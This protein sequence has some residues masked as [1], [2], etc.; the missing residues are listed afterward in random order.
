MATMRPEEVDEPDQTQGGSVKQRSFFSLS[1]CAWGWE[2]VTFRWRAFDF[3]FQFS[4]PLLDL[5]LSLALPTLP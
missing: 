4:F 2:E 3:T 1:V 5:N